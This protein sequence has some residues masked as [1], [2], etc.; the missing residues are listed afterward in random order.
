MERFEY[1]IIECS[2]QSK[3]LDETHNYLNELGSIGWEIVSQS[4]P[5]LNCLI[6]TLKRKIQ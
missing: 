2:T 1:K 3:K 4:S 5:F 6:F